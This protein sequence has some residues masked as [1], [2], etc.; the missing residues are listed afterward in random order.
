MKS[1]TW[2]D[3][4]LAVLGNLFTAALTFALATVIG[5][6]LSANT[7]LSLLM[8]FTFPLAGSALMAFLLKRRGLRLWKAVCILILFLI[9]LFLMGQD[10]HPV[11]KFFS[12]IT[13]HY[14]PE[15]MGFSLLYAMIYC[16]GLLAGA[17]PGWLVYRLMHRKRP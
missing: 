4:A 10:L 11:T 8:L 1:W 6:L 5:Y 7:P 17:L 14:N 13:G 9:A 2:K 16:G 15:A 3:L 12:R